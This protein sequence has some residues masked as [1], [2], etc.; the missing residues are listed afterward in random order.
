MKQALINKMDTSSMTLTNNLCSQKSPFDRSGV[1]YDHGASTSNTKGKTVF[2]L[3]VANTTPH[4][5][6]SNN[7][8]SSTKKKNVSR[9]IRTPTCHH[10]GKK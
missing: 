2:V 6:L 10:C 8:L 7:V 9:A 4:V 5:A 3:N 1:G